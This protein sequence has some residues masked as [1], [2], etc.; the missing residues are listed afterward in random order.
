MCLQLSQICDGNRQCP[1][2]DD[3]DM[4][5]FGCLD[6][7]DCE[8]YI[9]HCRT[10]NLTGADLQFIP[11]TARKIDISSNPLTS[12]GLFS[13]PK[14]F[15]HLVVLLAVNCK[16]RDITDYTFT[17]TR[18]LITLDL[19]YNQ[20][21]Q[22]KNVTFF[23]LTLLQ[24]LNLRGNSKLD[25]IE[26]HSFSSLRLLNRLSIT[27]TKL[28]E[29][30]PETFAGLDIDELDI[31]GNEISEVH[32]YAFNDLGTRVLKI[33]G[34]DI[35][36]FDSGIF[37]GLRAVRRL[38]TPAFK[39]CCYR[40]SSLPEENCYPHKDEFSSCDDLMRN[41]ALQTL[42]WIVCVLALVGNL[43]SIIY[44]ALYDR[45]RL[46]TGFGMFVTNLAASD[47]LMGVYM[48][49]IAI[50]DLSFRQR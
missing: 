31:S 14:T 25:I 41:S 13:F 36:E 17:K 3:E 28:S 49:I 4:C 35:R 18:H 33:Q 40:P 27:Q 32:N 24:R 16:I 1:F 30:L 10:G 34:N 22:I 38:E 20:I 9:V 7:C 45:E 21:S 6:K 11:N 50:A 15:P 2:G 46:K 26:P 47:F 44:R 39:F 12:S 23:G 48:M 8:R 29:I 19:S 37:A 42:L 5:D 43:S